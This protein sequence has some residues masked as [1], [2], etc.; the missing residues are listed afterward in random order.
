[1]VG[2]T[3]LILPA[4]ADGD[5]STVYNYETHEMIYQDETISTIRSILGLP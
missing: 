4:L 1:M 5:D 3:D 2:L